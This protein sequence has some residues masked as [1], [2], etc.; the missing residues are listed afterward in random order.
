M[1][2]FPRRLV[3]PSPHALQKSSS[4]V[5]DISVIHP[6]T[7]SFAGGAARTPEFAAAARDASKGRTYRQ[8]SSALPFVLMSVES[9]G[10]LGSPALTLHGDLTD[11][12]V[13]A[14]RPGLSRAAFISGALRELSVALCRGTASLCRSGAYVATRAAGQTLMRGLA[15]PLVEVVEACFAPRLWIWGH[16]FGFAFR[17]VALLCGMC[18]RLLLVLFP[19]GGPFVPSLSVIYHTVV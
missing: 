3:S 15:Q 14:G 13:Q 18:V 16:W 11:R 8:V 1:F 2:V 4:L 17:C 12:R 5:C 9:F 19:V 10:R 7:A 6:A